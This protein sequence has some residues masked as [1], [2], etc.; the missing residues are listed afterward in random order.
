MREVREMQLDNPSSELHDRLARLPD[1]F[2]LAE[3]CTLLP[4]KALRKLSA[5]VIKGSIEY[6]NDP[7]NRME[8]AMLLGS[9]IATAE[10]TVAAGKAAGRIAARRKTTTRDSE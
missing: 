10:E 8:Y 2:E 4:A 5:E 9:W 1:E 3:L 6:L 7:D